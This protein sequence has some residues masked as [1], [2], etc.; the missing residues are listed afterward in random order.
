MPFTMAW[1][2]SWPDSLLV[3]ISTLAPACG[4]G[5]AALLLPPDRS[6]CGLADPECSYPCIGAVRRA[7]RASAEPQAT[8]T[9]GSGPGLPARDS[10][11]LREVAGQQR[12]WTG[13][14]RAHQKSARPE[15]PDGPAVPAECS[16][17]CIALVARRRSRMCLDAIVRRRAARGHVALSLVGPTQQR[18]GAPGSAPGLFLAE[19]A[20]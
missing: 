10:R 6:S 16:Y 9:R 3:S 14:F 13:R 11:D 18:A 4:A 12:S 8:A 17:S 19:R 7:S 5:A 2:L 20:A 15:R 1:I